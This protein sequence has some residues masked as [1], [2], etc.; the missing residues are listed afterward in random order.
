MEK[1]LLVSDVY[2][3]LIKKSKYKFINIDEVSAYLKEKLQDNYTSELSVEVKSALKDHE[4]LQFFREDTYVEN[5]KYYYST[6]NWLAIRDLY[7][8]PVQAKNKLG[9]YSWQDSAEINWED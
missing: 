1:E 6:G 3:N 4:K 8:N 7:D 2:E 9:W 5:S